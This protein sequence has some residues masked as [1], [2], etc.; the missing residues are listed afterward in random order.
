MARLA[1]PPR[2][3]AALTGPQRVPYHWRLFPAWIIATVSVGDLLSRL[4]AWWAARPTHTRVLLTLAFSVF[5]IELVLRRVAPRSRFYAGWTKVFQT[6]GKFWTAVILSIVYFLSVAGV[7]VF[8]RLRGK[9]LL[10]RAL[11]PEPT[12]WRPHE[13][14]PLGPRAAVRHQF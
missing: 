13:P 7:A 2:G 5:L 12:F 9:D 14:N 10:D 11:D 8:M 3:P 4:A 1:Q 6:I